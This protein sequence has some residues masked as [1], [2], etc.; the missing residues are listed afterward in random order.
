[1]PDVSAFFV[2]PLHSVLGLLPL[3]FSSNTQK[4]REEK[5]VKICGN[6]VAVAHLNATQF[7]NILYMLN[8]GSF[9]DFMPYLIHSI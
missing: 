2:L 3:S 1:M 4:Q 6:K 9:Q 8:G 7:K 5:T